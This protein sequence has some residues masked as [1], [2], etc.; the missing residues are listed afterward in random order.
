VAD[1]PDDLIDL[2]RAALADRYELLREIGRGGMA[3]VFLARDRRHD[4]RVAI[5]V[6]RPELSLA[7]AGPR[8]EREVQIAS[9]LQHPNI[10]PLLDS[11]ATA[12]LSYL[13]MP[14]VEGE[15]LAARLHRDSRL[16]V[17]EAVRL[18]AEVADG[19]MHAHQ[20]GFIH[21][22]IKPANVLLSHSHAMLAD[23]GI[24]RAIDLSTAE[25]ITESGVALGTV[26]YMSPE[27]SAGERVDGRADQY[28]L[29]CVLYEMLAGTPP[30]T[31]S[32]TQA[33]MARHAVDPVPSLR[34]VR[35][36]V[37][38]ALEAAIEKAL[39]KA[40]EDRFATIRQFRDAIMQAALQPV[41]AAT[42]TAVRP[43]RRA[44][45]RRP[46]SIVALVGVFVAVAVAWPTLLAK[47]AAL[48]PNRVLVLPLTLSDGWPSSR[49]AGED[50]ATLIGSAMDGAGGLRWVDGWQLL[51]TAQREDR[52]GIAL[53]TALALAKSR[54]CAY[55]LT[56]KLVA[57]GDS[58]DVFLELHDVRGD[59][60]LKRSTGRTASAADG[61]RGSLAAITSLLPSLIATNIPDVESAW[62]ARAPQA[63]AHFLLAEG[64]FRRVM[65]PEALAEYRLAVEADSAFALAAIRGAQAA[66]WNHRP[67]EADALVRLALT[68]PL[69]LRYQ[70]FATGML[71]YING[72][73]DSA[74]ARFRD[75]IAIDSTMVAAW[76]QL[77]ET[78]VHLLP[79]QGRTDALAEAAF[80]GARRL[81]STSAT[82][83]FHLVELV[84]RRG[85]TDAAVRLATQ[86]RAVSQD[87]TLTQQAD[88]V[89]A[90]GSDGRFGVPLE[91][92]VVQRPLL[93]LVA[94]RYLAAS[95]RTASCAT[96]GFVELLR[97]DTAATDV[98]DGRRFAAL[99]GLVSLHYG[100][101]QPDSGT[102]VLQAFHARWNQ[103]LSLYLLAA[104]V[105]PAI[106]ERARELARQDA[107]AAGADYRG[108]AY[109][110]RLWELGVWASRDG[111]A[112]TAA[113]IARELTRRAAT[114]T[115]LDSLLAASMTAHAALAAADT[116]DAVRRFELLILAPA[117]R[118]ELS[119]HEAAPL[120]IDRLVL[121]QLLVQRRQYERALGVLDVLDSGLPA[122]FPLYRRAALQARLAAAEALG[123]PRAAELRAQVAA[124]GK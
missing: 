43:A 97:A 79:S 14:F 93:L 11:G 120:G 113:V 107:K 56:G 111:Q 10:L 106:A 45:W 24:A 39:E 30:F 62:R 108:M 74:A 68:Q 12:G 8:F 21:R 58:A 6:L 1:A 49:T 80:N 44:W 76:M 40:P 17:E 82:L 100:S 63:V 48:D 119:W 75:A 57:R 67:A 51:S 36:G 123:D 22:D 121:G 102:A 83:K 26:S 69:P 34:T 98:A 118:A 61:W 103:G 3:T 114:G 19:L 86:F 53:A 95:P 38:E 89:A 27:Q 73:A 104:P 32:T 18:A 16:T 47:P 55:L 65:I 23:F 37:P 81:D 115:R 109:P 124:I 29:A 5:K 60:V 117:P 31:G 88:L 42:R 13:V 116:T 20:A 25:L 4:S 54:Q 59:S 46:G 105:V 91:S 101:G 94:S 9:T 28:A 85:D 78:Y 87:T 2:V 96:G 64:A 35:H 33:V 71:A 72:E 90:C 84:R 50:A 112:A 110:T 66:A 15:S 99:L 70:R 7:A 52:N 77:G 41:T 92:A 122:V